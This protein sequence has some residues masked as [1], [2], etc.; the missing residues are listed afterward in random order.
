M[1]GGDPESTYDSVG[2][3]PTSVY[4]EGPGPVVEIC[5]AYGV[6]GGGKLGDLL[7]DLLGIHG[8]R[9]GVMVTSLATAVTAASQHLICYDPHNED[10]S[11][12]AGVYPKS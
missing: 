5:R 10:G 4:N 3:C 12:Q 7:G 11:T 1:E 6:W 2:Y 8:H 9:W